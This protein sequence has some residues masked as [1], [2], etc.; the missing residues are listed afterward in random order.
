VAAVNCVHVPTPLRSYT[1]GRAEV[2]VAGASLADVL[3]GL[4][5]QFPGFRFRIV[6]EQ[7]RLRPHIKLYARGAFARALDTPVGPD[8]EVHIICALSGG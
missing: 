4:D 8:D 6:D 3:A 1:A 2:E 5:R 7:D